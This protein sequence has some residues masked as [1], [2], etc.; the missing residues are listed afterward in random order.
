MRGLK[1]M[2]IPLELYGNNCFLDGKK[3]E[4]THTLAK[5]IQV[6][7]N[8][9]KQMYKLM[10]STACF[11]RLSLLY[12]FNG[13]RWG[14]EWQYALGAKAI[15]LKD[16][17]DPSK[18]HPV[19]IR[20]II[21]QEFVAPPKITIGVLYVDKNLPKNYWLTLMSKQQEQLMSILQ[22]VFEINDINAD[23]IFND[24]LWTLKRIKTFQFHDSHQSFTI[25]FAS[26]HYC[27][28]KMNSNHI[29]KFDDAIQV[30]WH[31][32][33]AYLCHGAYWPIH[34]TNQLNNW[35]VNGFNS[36]DWIDKSQTQ[37]GWN[38]LYNIKE[39]VF[40]IHDCVLMNPTTKRSL[41]EDI[42]TLFDTNYGWTKN[43]LY[44]NNLIHES[45]QIQ[46]PCGP[47]WICKA[48]KENACDL[49]FE[50]LNFYPPNQ[51]EIVW[52]CNENDN[53]TF[54]ILDGHNGLCMTLMKPFKKS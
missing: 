36:L 17:D 8:N 26:D 12:I 1:Q 50:R 28:V 30:T 38:Y 25:N 7:H 37:Y 2:I 6:S 34:K 24:Q 49:C 41:P 46:A 10:V 44:L 18:P 51:W 54:R 20:W 19:I 4:L 16:P 42:K 52:H 21:Q 15:N 33:T 43:M 40:W 3:L 9:F 27:L 45:T 14:S 31:N 23:N 5:N 11:R 32:Q 39:P 48:H 22:D 53:K 35:N 13:G 29:F 47:K